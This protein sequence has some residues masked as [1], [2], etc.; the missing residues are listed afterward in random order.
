[1]RRVRAATFTAGGA[2]NDPYDLERR[3]MKK[4]IWETPSFVELRMDAEV[5]SYQDDFDP[6]REEPAFAEGDEPSPS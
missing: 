1:V 6:T 5:G 2:V 4:V 3:T